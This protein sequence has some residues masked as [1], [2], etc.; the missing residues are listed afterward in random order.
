M[1]DVTAW[2]DAVLQREETVNRLRNSVTDFCDAVQG[3]RT[4]AVGQLHSTVTRRVRQYHTINNKCVSLTLAQGEDPDT[5]QPAAREVEEMIQRFTDIYSDWVG[6]EE[7]DDDFHDA[8]DVMEPSEQ[9]GDAHANPRSDDT[10]PKTRD[11]APASRQQSSNATAY[12]PTVDDAIASGSGFDDAPIRRINVKEVTAPVA[13]GCDNFTPRKLEISVRKEQLGRLTEMT[14][15]DRELARRLLDQAERLADVPQVSDDIVDSLIKEVKVLTARAAQPTTAIKDSASSIAMSSPVTTAV[16]D[17]RAGWTTFTSSSMVDL[18]DRA[19]GGP[20]RTGVPLFA[21]GAQE[22]LRFRGLFDTR[23]APYLKTDY[24]RFNQLLRHLSGTAYDVVS[25]C[26]L[27]ANPSTAYTEACQQLDRE[28]GQRH[29]LIR[30]SLDKLLTGPQIDGRNAEALRRFYLD[31]VQAEATVRHIDSSQLSSYDVLLK[32][33]RR[34]PAYKQRDWMK[35]EYT[36]SQTKPATLTDFKNFIFEWRNLASRQLS[37]DLAVTS[38]P[39]FGMGQTKQAKPSA[40]AAAAA[41]GSTPQRTDEQRHGGQPPRQQQQQQQQQQP[42]VTSKCRVCAGSCRLFVKCRVF[43]NKSVDERRAILRANNVCLNCFR[44]DHIVK[45]CNSD[46]RCSTCGG[47]HHSMLHNDPVRPQPGN[48]AQAGNSSQQHYNANSAAGHA[49]TSV[50]HGVVPVIV[51]AGGRVVQTY[52]LLDNGSDKSFCTAWLTNKLRPP[53]KP[54]EYNLSTLTGQNT[55]QKGLECSF[56]VKGVTAEPRELAMNSVW[57]VD[58]LPVAASSA[59]TVSDIKRYPH[60]QGVHVPTSAVGPVNLLIGTDVPVAHT[61]VDFRA[62]GESEPYAVKTAL[63][64]AIRGPSGAESVPHVC[65]NFVKIE[66]QAQHGM[67]P[68]TTLDEKLEAMWSTDFIEQQTKQKS[69]SVQDREAIEKIQSSMTVTDGRYQI[70]LPWKEPE[71]VHP[72]SLP[73]AHKRLSQLHRRLSSNE[74]LHQLYNAAMQKYIDAGHAEPAE[75]TSSVR[76]WYLPHQPVVHPMKPGKVRV[77]FDA[78]ARFGKVSLN[79]QL[80][81]GPD[82]ANSLVGVLIRFRQHKVA[83]SAD[84]EAMFCQVRVAPEDRDAFRFLW[85][86]NGDLQQQPKHYR[87]TC[88]VFG[89]ISSPFIANY[90]VKQTVKDAGD[91]ISEATR[92]T[93]TEQ[94]YVDDLLASGSDADTVIKLRQ[95]ITTTLANRGFRLTKFVSNDRAVLADIPE[96]E[97]APGV[98][99]IE[100]GDNLPTERALGVSW[101]VEKDCFLFKVQQL[102]DVKSKREILS[103]VASLYDP[104]GLVVPVTLKPKILLQECHR[105]KL[106]WDAQIPDDIHHAWTTWRRQLH[107]IEDCMIPR[108]YSVRDADVISRELHTF[109]DAS[110]SG[111]GAA[112]YLRTVYSDAPPDVA[113]VIG[114]ARVTPIKAPSIPRLELVAALTGARISKV[115]LQEL[116]FTITRQV[117]W[118]DSTIVLGYIRSKDKRFKTYVRNRVDEIHEHTDVTAWRHVDSAQ[119][120]ADHASRGID[121]GNEQ[122]LSM[123]GQGPSFLKKGE[124]TWPVDPTITLPPDAEVIEEAT[125]LAAVHDGGRHGGQNQDVGL[126]ALI[127]YHSDWSKLSR[128]TAW[129]IRIRDW[130]R[131]PRPRQQMDRLLLLDELKHAQDVLIAHVQNR[132]FKN[133]VDRLRSSQQLQRS[134]SLRMLNPQ[135]RDG[136][137]VLHGRASPHTP[138]RRQYILPNKH[139]LTELIISSVHREDAHT[140]KHQTLATLRQRFWIINGLSAVKRVLNKCVVCRKIE[141]RPIQPMMAPLRE[142]QVTSGGRPFKHVGVDYFGPIETKFGRRGRIKRWVCLFTCLSTRAVHL[143]LAYSLDTEAFLG[144]YSRFTNRRGRPVRVFSDNGTNFVGADR[145][146]RTQIEAWNN[147][148]VDRIMKQRG[149]EWHF[150]P[151]TASHMGGAWERLIRSTRKILRALT[152]ERLLT[153]QQLHTFLT[154][155][156]RILNARPLTS[157]SDDPR[158]CT[159]L[160]PSM[161][162]GSHDGQDLPIGAS[163]GDGDL[164]RRWWRAIQSMTHTFWFRWRREYLENQQQRT[165]WFTPTCNLKVNDLVLCLEKTCSR[166]R[167]PLARVTEVYQS[168]DGQVRSAKVRTAT[169]H[170]YERPVTGLALLEAD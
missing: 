1:T 139:P 155:C 99:N 23:I 53:S 166:W 133:D 95:E 127:Q 70:A 117:Y 163:L 168:G 63:G 80:L 3:K 48:G 160:T 164:L 130:L 28:Y 36:I 77:V 138:G 131:S 32:L 59:A 78:A 79:D 2:E 47:K 21:G 154:E 40:R 54:I 69:M 10:Q 137:L 66:Q 153:D 88:H 27:A 12:Q 86:P 111:Y 162:L 116:R 107:K 14:N 5:L 148:H 29:E 132:H 91:S 4:S 74:E 13:N 102:D 50:F 146:L 129:L 100:A 143:E 83:I 115:A 34:L 94:F 52:A 152:S 126:T 97:R 128:C 149:T 44:S 7:D 150:N 65:S 114:K 30:S 169:G 22:Y 17:T 124:D 104:L 135:L 158:D 60:L 31:V 170:E 8:S 167:W 73:M 41:S 119:N 85:W 142:E 96:T 72:S 57:T 26:I 151:P 125:V 76:H 101:N 87:M 19:M 92:T 6:D 9:Q 42:S 90:A 61:P 112:V 122:Q 56:M 109:T 46:K 140:G 113:L 98:V 51:R 110:E 37:Q 103:A 67:M 25:P 39:K 105:R 43:H 55:P 161:L 15:S 81:K 18:Y 93:I 144:A 49:S 68:E 159:A 71:Q 82:L 108:R 157:V 156:E 89:A 145:E 147:Y 64:W 106:G 35:N 165:K 75:N 121:A 11:S 20:E 33:A 134:S 45:D 62:G 118:T 141:G 120:P 58:K 84:I 136:M 123:W 16:T 24:E 38:A